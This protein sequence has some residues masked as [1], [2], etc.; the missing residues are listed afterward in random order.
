MGKDL[1][2]DF[3]PLLVFCSFDHKFHL[4]TVYCDRDA[5]KVIIMFSVDFPQ[6]L[7]TEFE[8]YLTSPACNALD[9][10]TVPCS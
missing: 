7:V 3:L 6:L 8:P 4:M 2:L 1:K 10:N 9:F 5:V